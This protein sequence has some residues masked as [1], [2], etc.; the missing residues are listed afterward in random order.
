M[1]ICDAPD[2]P[3]ITAI[4]EIPGIRKEEIGV[5]VVPEGRL[6]ISGER[7]A[8]PLLHNDSD[9]TLPRYPVHEIKYGRFERT[10]DVPPGLEVCTRSPRTHLAI[11]LIGFSFFKQV[12]DITASLTDGML[13]VS[14]PRVTPNSPR[15]HSLS[16]SDGT[17]SH[18]HAQMLD[19][20]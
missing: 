4:L 9:T 13:T 15:R 12:S 14:W 6:I 16:Q 1:E 3:V 19:A 2:S 7:R 11:P 5:T 17:S 18:I 8:P 20:Q 10:I